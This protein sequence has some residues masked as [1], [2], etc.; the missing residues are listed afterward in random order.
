MSSPVMAGMFLLLDEQHPDWSP[1]AVKS[2]VMTTAYQDVR[3]NDRTTGPAVRLRCRALSAPARAARPGLAYDAGFLDSSASTA[4]PTS[5]TTSRQRRP[6]CGN[7]EASGV[8]TTIENLN[9][10][11]HGVSSLA[12]WCPSSARSPTSPAHGHLRASVRTARHEYRAPAET[13]ARS[14]TR[15]PPFEVTITNARAPWTPTGSWARYRGP[16]PAP[17]VKGEAMRRASRPEQENGSGASGSVSIPVQV[18]DRGT[19]QYRGGRLAANERGESAGPDQTF[20]AASP[21]G[22]NSGA[23]GGPTRPTSGW[24]TR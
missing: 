17:R 20:A 6:T 21:A 11:T 16:A 12:G 8:P 15:A 9:Y 24:R 13:A 2:A 1:A 14:P 10:R 23:V 22:H 5:G 4:A 19:V 18:G 7:L 3:D